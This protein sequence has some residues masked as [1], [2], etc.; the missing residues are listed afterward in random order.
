M[1]PPRPR[2]PASVDVLAPLVDGGV[3]GA[4]EVAVAD[5]V[6]RMTPE[7]GEAAVVQAVAVAALGLRLG[8]SCVDL[9]DAAALCHAA[10]TDDDA[11]APRLAPTGDWIDRLAASDLVSEDPDGGP[12]D[13]PLVL[14]AARGRVWLAR[15]ALYERTLTNRLFDRATPGGAFGAEA[16]I[17][18]VVDDVFAHRGDGPDEPQRA[19]VSQALRRRLSFLV[20]GP[21]TGKTWTVGRLLDAVEALDAPQRARSVA[22]AAPTGK[23]A[24]RLTEAVGGR[25][26]ATTIHRLLGLRPGGTPGVDPP[27]ALREDLVVVDE[28]SM[29]DLTMMTKLVGALHPDAHVVFVGDPDQLVSVEVGSV[30]RDVVDAAE[31]VTSPLHGSVVRLGRSHRFGGD[32][33]VLA[34]VIRSGDGDGAIDVLS[35]PDRSTL[36]LVDPSSTRQMVELTESVI[37][38][39]RPMVAAA[40]L[41]RVGDALAAARATKVLTATRAGRLGLD[42]WNEKFGSALGFRPGEWKP[43]RPV[44]VTRNDPVNEVFNGD[45]GVV[46]PGVDDVT[47][48]QVALAGAHEA[49][50]LAP[51][52]L[53]RHEDWWAMTVHKSQGSEFDDVVVSLPEVASPILS[54]ELLYT[55][56]TR[57][58]TRLTVVGHPAIVRDAV[59]HRIDRASGLRDRLSGG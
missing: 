23:A 31:Q 38:A 48:V 34:D 10:A 50:L 37:E 3:F 11:E 53:R 33:G 4:A 36:R 12:W 18:A 29:I 43:G 59:E 30:L 28:A 40:R 49:R 16:A 56:V 46:V 8:H 58:Q 55:A 26:H 25:L 57:A 41:G 22:L 21:G 51:S 44:I 39:T 54:R 5:A 20:G 32:L 14:D 27:R 7:G 42:W 9:A 17:A 1:N 6:A 45:T 52:R 15:Y 19:A 35:D 47:G 2:L 13:R 24:E